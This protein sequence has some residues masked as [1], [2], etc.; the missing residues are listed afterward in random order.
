M[1]KSCLHCHQASWITLC[2][3]H[4]LAA[5]VKWLGTLTVTEMQ[6]RDEHD[7]TMLV[8][9]GVSFISILPVTQRLRL[10]FLLPESIGIL[11]PNWFISEAYPF[12]L[13]STKFCSIGLKRDG[14]PTGI[15]HSEAGCREADASS[16]TCSGG[17]AQDGAAKACGLFQVFT[18]LLYDSYSVIVACYR[19]TQCTTRSLLWTQK[20]WRSLFWDPDSI[21]EALGGNCVKGKAVAGDLYFRFH[22][23]PPSKQSVGL[24]IA[25]WAR[26]DLIDGVAGWLICK[27]HRRRQ[28]WWQELGAHLHL[29]WRFALSSQYQY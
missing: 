15:C 25:W 3:T 24:A 2:S 23:H 18:Y 14:L 19:M 11:P 21:F 17:H 1:S 29:W 5:F 10:S 4:W 27:H 12:L 26:D 7:S 28:W 20:V 9:E 8:V 13:C 16:K 22:S 6:R